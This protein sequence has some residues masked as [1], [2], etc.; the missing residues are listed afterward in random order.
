MSK[1]K[2]IQI[3]GYIVH[4]AHRAKLPSIYPAPWEFRHFEPSPDSENV[5]VQPHTI[6]VE[7]P[8]DFDPRP[9]MVK[10]LEAKKDKARAEFAALVTQI[11]RQINEL[12]AIECAGV[13]E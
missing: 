10:A 3:H 9:G 5:A 8:A 11:D 4:D 2:T 12:T 7:I 13:A 1:T 6:T